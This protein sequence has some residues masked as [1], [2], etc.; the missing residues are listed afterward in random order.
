MLG[1]IASVVKF[2][3]FIIWKGVWDGQMYQECHKNIFSGGNIYIVK[4]SGWMSGAAFQ[5][6]VQCVVRPYGGVHNSSLYLMLDQFSVHMQH[7]NTFTLQQIGIEVDL[8]QWGAL[9][10]Y[11][12]WIKG[13]KNPINS[14]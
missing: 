8:F 11:T 12:Y 14:T 6:W 1:C 3:V 9:L 4:P 2:P 10:Y 13:C 7:N 5:V